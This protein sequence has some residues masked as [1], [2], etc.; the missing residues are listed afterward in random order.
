MLGKMI[1]ALFVAW[2]GMMLWRYFKWK[3]SSEEVPGPKNRRFVIVCHYCGG[4][5]Q[6]DDKFG[7]DDSDEKW[8]KFACTKCKRE[9]K[10][11]GNNIDREGGADGSQSHSNRGG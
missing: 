1:I 9:G 7:L 5:E 4:I 2:T 11:A 8:P 10:N 6:T 3:S